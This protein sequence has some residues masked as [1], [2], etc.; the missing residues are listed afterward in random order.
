MT[1]ASSTTVTG[2][3]AHDGARH[4]PDSSEAST[5]QY[6]S[7]AKRRFSRTSSSHVTLSGH[8]LSDAERLAAEKA[9]QRVVG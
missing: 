9:A 4:D 1:P 3:T 6:H 5:T 8:P 2:T 7:R